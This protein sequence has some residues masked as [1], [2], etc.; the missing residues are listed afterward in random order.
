[1][2]QSYLSSHVSKFRRDVAPSSSQPT[3][4]ARYFSDLA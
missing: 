4:S 3:T 1:M 2:P